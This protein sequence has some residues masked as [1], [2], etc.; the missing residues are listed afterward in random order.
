MS[1]LVSL[2][3]LFLAKSYE[4]SYRT[5]GT[6][7]FQDLKEEAVLKV[8]ASLQVSMALDSTPL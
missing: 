4:Y 1:S 8:T 7:N 2:I 3:P 6:E 5:E